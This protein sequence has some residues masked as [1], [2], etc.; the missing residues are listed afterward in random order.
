MQGPAKSTQLS[1]LCR[2]PT[3]QQGIVEELGSNPPSNTYTGARPFVSTL[4]CPSASSVEC[5]KA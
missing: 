5:A 2:L 1:I 4:A 3:G